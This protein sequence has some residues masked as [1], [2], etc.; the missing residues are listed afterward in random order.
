MEKQAGLIIR[1]GRIKYAWISNR[2]AYI[3]NIGNVADW[4]AWPGKH[5]SIECRA[6]MD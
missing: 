5:V 4:Q 3:M 1:E 2:A 6:Y